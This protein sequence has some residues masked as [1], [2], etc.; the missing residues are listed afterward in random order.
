MLYFCTRCVSRVKSGIIEYMNRTELQQALEAKTAL[1]WDEFCE[2]YPQLCRFD[3]PKI[4][5]NG[6]F[7]RTAGCCEVER[8]VIHMGYKFFAKHSAVMFSV[9]LPHELA[10]Q[11]DYNLN[12][13]PKNNRWHGKTWRKIMVEFGLEPNPYHTLEI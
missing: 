4:V 1:L 3:A 13:L 6:R 8:N 10:H 9:I 2:M 12:G 5:I 11:V 7:T